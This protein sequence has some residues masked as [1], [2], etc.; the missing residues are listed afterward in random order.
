MEI[1]TEFNR[2]DTVYY[3][4]SYGIESMIVESI[5]IRIE[6]Q[7]LREEYYS[8]GSSTGRCVSELFLSVDEYVKDLRNN[9]KE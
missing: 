8:K 9:V 6:S 2:G 1:K 3:I 7:G 5:V 4:S